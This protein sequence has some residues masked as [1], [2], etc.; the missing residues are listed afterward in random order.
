MSSDPG[1]SLL[2]TAAALASILA[3]AVLVL[4]ASAATPAADELDI[5]AF[6]AVPAL[7]GDFKRLQRSDGGE[8]RIDVESISG[9]L[10][11]WG[12]TTRVSSEEGVQ[13]FGW[14]VRPGRWSALQFFGRIGTG[15]VSFSYRWPGLKQRLRVVLGTAYR[16]RSRGGVWAVSGKVGRHEADL[17][18]TVLGF[19]VKE[20]PTASWDG[21]LRVEEV[22][23]LR[24]TARGARSVV[25]SLERST[26]WYVQGVGLVAGRSESTTWQDGVLMDETPPTDV[27][28]VEGVVGGDPVVL[29]AP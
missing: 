25:Q 1:G 29:P 8:R 20:T 13:W 14:N 2:R 24:A 12:Q 11:G 6:V 7:Q 23:T 26:S 17:D 18:Y 16:A 3:S 4:P 10:R 28:L 19:E 9:I 27:W 5:T 21:A 22:L 15:E